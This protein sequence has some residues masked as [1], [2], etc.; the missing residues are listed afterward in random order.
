MTVSLILFQNWPFILADV[1]PYLNLNS[2]YYVST[3]KKISEKDLRDLQDHRQQ[4]SSTNKKRKE[5]VC[6]LMK[7]SE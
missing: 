5:D 3:S 2:K 7:K 6:A 1:I 4:E